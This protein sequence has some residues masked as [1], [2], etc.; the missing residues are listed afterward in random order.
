MV[1]PRELFHDPLAQKSIL[2][3]SRVPDA[4]VLD[5][6]SL[7]AISQQRHARCS[8]FAENDEARTVISIAS[9]RPSAG[10]TKKEGLRAISKRHV[11]TVRPKALLCSAGETRRYYARS[12]VPPSVRGS[13]FN[14]SNLRY[15]IATYVLCPSV[16]E[17]LL[18]P[19]VFARRSVDAKI[20]RDERG[21]EGNG[22]KI[23]RKMCQDGESVRRNECKTCNMR[24]KTLFC[25]RISYKSVFS[26]N[27]IRVTYP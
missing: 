23:N 13:S 20:A 14:R 27:T 22:T 19:V 11:A 3:S 7:E 10:Q 26:K 18:S 6:F 1:D 21:S 16:R 5:G 17:T 25:P 2:P 15:S 24:I 8:R 12:R 9:I 4:S